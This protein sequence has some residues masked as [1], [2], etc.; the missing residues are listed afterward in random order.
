M[1]SVK[2][3]SVSTF[4]KF[5]LFSIIFG[6][7]TLT[8]LALLPG[9]I[10]GV[11]IADGLC[12]C[13]VMI[14][15]SRMLIVKASFSFHYYRGLNYALLLCFWAITGAL[16]LNIASPFDFSETEFA[17]SFAKLNFY[18][19][20]SIFLNSYFR[21][22]PNNAIHN[23]VLSVLLV[24]A[25]VAIYIFI[26]MTFK[27]DLPYEF[28]GYGP[29]EKINIGNVYYRTGGFVVARGIFEEPSLLGIFQSLGLSFLFFSSTASTSH[30]KK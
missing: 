20:L 7:V 30:Q 19:I 24:N 28:F 11:S 14:L 27:I 3:A 5:F 21:K 15:I 2:R 16:F 13:V 4:D 12:A 26:V 29:R 22:F 1:I 9:V 10:D 6:G 18:V 23:I 17:K 8:K 25:L